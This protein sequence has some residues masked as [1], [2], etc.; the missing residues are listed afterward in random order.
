MSFLVLAGNAS[1]MS[2]AAETGHRS[3]VP[4]SWCCE[5]NSCGT[6]NT[7][8]DDRSGGAGAP[9]NRERR[10]DPEEARLWGV[11]K[12][13]RFCTGVVRNPGA[14]V[15]Y[16]SCQDFCVIALFTPGVVTTKCGR[17]AE[18]LQMTV[19]SSIV[20]QNRHADK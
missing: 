5:G 16:I 18:S 12:T 4:P 3:A 15:S 1:R 19:C 20:V 17:T 8:A 2:P 10:E 7:G 14:L 13:C 6:Q 11:G 9:P